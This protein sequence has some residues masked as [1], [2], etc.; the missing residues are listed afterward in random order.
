MSFVLIWQVSQLVSPFRSKSSFVGIKATNLEY[1]ASYYLVRLVLPMS[2]IKIFFFN[3]N[4]EGKTI[5]YLISLLLG[6]N[7]NYPISDLK[8]WVTRSA[9]EVGKLN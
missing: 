8:I 3:S 5:F 6:M 2:W 7:R 4:G 9:A 1:K